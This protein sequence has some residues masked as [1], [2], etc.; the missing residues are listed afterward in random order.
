MA[1]SEAQLKDQSSVPTRKPGV[2]HQLQKICVDINKTVGV[3][4]VHSGL[5]LSR[6][7]TFNQQGPEDQAGCPEITKAFTHNST[8]TIS[9][10]REVECANKG[11]SSSALVLQRVAEGPQQS[12]RSGKS[13]LRG[14]VSIVTASTNRTRVVDHTSFLVEWE[15]HYKTQTHN[16]NG[17][18]CIPEGMGGNLQRCSD[19]GSLVHKGTILAHKLPR[20]VGSNASNSVLCQRQK[21]YNHSTVDG[22]HHSSIICK[23]HGRNNIRAISPVG[24][25]P[26][27]VVS[28][29]RDPSGS[30]TSP[31]KTECH[32]RC[33]VESPVRSHGLDDP[34]VSVQKDRQEDGS[35]ESGFICIPIDSSASSV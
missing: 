14:P 5:R 22:Q 12:P 20:I 19:R 16:V 7:E 31:K 4:R 35:T 21:E 24:K 17:D 28:S 18:R 13:G 1:E 25:R 10:H 11:H 30:S 3:S 29:E 26:V 23:Q 34:A 27:D 2:H 8:G 6:A 33:R 32:S 15:K 9:I